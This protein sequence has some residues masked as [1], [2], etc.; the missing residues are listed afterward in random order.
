VEFDEGPGLIHG[1]LR[2]MAYCADSRKA[3]GRMCEWLRGVL[4]P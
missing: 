3:F 2:S 1:Y 4:A